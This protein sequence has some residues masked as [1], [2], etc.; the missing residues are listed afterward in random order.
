MQTGVPEGYISLHD[1]E[2]RELLPLVLPLCHL[3]CCA[4]GTHLL[5]PWAMLSTGSRLVVE[6]KKQRPWP[7]GTLWWA[8]PKPAPAGPGVWHIYSV[9]AKPIP[10]VL[11]WSPRVARSL[12]EMVWSDFL[13]SIPP[14]ILGDVQWWWTPSFPRKLIICLSTFV[15]KVRFYAK[16]NSV[17]PVAAWQDSSFNPESSKLPDFL[18]IA[19]ISQDDVVQLFSH[20]QFFVTPW[21]V[22]L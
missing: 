12:S 3:S 20:V 5:S 18:H 9:H 11:W 8:S 6:W 17:T 4:T 21:T 22:A 13:S 7:V 16:T 15:K 1:G 19:S 2:S 10:S 14:K